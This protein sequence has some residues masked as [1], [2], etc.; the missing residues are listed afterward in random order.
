MATAIDQAEGKEGARSAVSVNVYPSM[1]VQLEDYG[2]NV[3]LLA[4]YI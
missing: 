1:C 2:H 4:A 3:H